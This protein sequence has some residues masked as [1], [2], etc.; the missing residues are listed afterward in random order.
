MQ[1]TCPQPVSLTVNVWINIQDASNASAQGGEGAGKGAG[2]GI[3]K[4][5]SKHGWVRP[6][7]QKADGSM[8]YV[9][10][11]EEGQG[12]KVR[13][14]HCKAAISYNRSSLTTCHSHAKMHG[15]TTA[16]AVLK[17]AEEGRR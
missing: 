2:K 14:Q 7:Y 13:C 5:G 11:G 3:K 6:L 1:Q 16:E 15:F 12:D 4:G 10:R 8:D 17:A 9:T